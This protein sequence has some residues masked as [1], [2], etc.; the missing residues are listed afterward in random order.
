MIRL[1]VAGREQQLNKMRICTYGV[2]TDD[3]TKL[4]ETEM[5]N[6]VR[7]TQENGSETGRHLYSSSLTYTEVVRIDTGR[8]VSFCETDEVETEQK[9]IKGDDFEGEKM[10]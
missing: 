9:C 8:S 4:S 2:S 3:S 7:T 1:S 10:L 6:T 5:G